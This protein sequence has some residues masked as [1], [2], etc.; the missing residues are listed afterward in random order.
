MN[1]KNDETMVRI[2]KETTELLRQLGIKGET[3]DTIIKRL[4]EFWKTKK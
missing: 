1:S 2:K 4:I 3:Y